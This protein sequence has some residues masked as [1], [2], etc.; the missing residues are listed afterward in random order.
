MWD[1]TYKLMHGEQLHSGYAVADYPSR[2][3]IVQYLSR[4]FVIQKIHKALLR[5][6]PRHTGRHR[7][8]VNRQ[9]IGCHMRTRSNHPHRTHSC[10]AYIRHCADWPV[11]D[12]RMSWAAAMWELY[13]VTGD[14][15]ALTE[16]INSLRLYRIYSSVKI[17]AVESEIR[18]PQ[19]IVD[20][21]GYLLVKTDPHRHD[22][23]RYL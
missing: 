17:A 16:I 12:D 9:S 22:V 2:S 8:N 11:S 6:I 14:A 18:Y 10:D 20:G 5:L 15:S 21:I 7:V 23:G 13:K 1:D 4:G 19:I 3:S